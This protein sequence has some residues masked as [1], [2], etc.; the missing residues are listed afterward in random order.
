MREPAP[1][2]LN[3]VGRLEAGSSGEW[4]QTKGEFT[5]ALGP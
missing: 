3:V 2:G 4:L 5:P 1:S